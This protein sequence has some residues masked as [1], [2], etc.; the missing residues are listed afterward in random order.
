MRENLERTLDIAAELSEDDASALYP[1]L[2]TL[3]REA[4]AFEATIFG[5]N[6]RIIATSSDGSVSPIPTMLSEEA[7]LKLHLENT[8]IGLEPQLDGNYFVRAAVALPLMQ[9]GI[10]TRVLQAMFLVG[11]R[12]GPLAESV[13]R[14]YTRYGELVFL[15]GPL[16]KQ[17]YVDIEYCGVAVAVDCR[18][19]GIFLC[20]ATC[21]TQFNIW[22]QVPGP[23][24]RA[25]SIHVYRW[26]QKMRS[27]FLST[28]ST[29]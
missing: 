11:E 6:F 10:E 13:Q 14:S 23:W 25:I 1:V 16:K 15:R 5:E 9:A 29:R 2:G 24:P 20:P 28:R 26:L 21:C 4:G 22:W 17:L 18:L 8:F 12:I 27:E 7:L 3:R 19:R